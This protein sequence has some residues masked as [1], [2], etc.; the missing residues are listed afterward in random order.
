MG[1]SPVLL[2]GSKELKT[3]RDAAVGSVNV[4][5]YKHKAFN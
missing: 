2:W 1:T 3:S 5:L 4:G